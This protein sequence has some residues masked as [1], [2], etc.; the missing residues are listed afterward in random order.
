MRTPGAEIEFAPI[1]STMIGGNGVPMLMVYGS[2]EDYYLGDDQLGMKT[3]EQWEEGELGQDKA[4]LVIEGL[5]HN[6]ITD[7]K[8]TNSLNNIESTLPAETRV[9]R[10]AE[11]LVLCHP[12]CHST[13]RKL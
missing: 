3:F 2:G 9:E 5:D 1:D 11:S 13:L 8:I 12:V 10:M 6:G 7:F 4:F